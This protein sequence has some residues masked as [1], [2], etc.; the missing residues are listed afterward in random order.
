MTESFN[1]QIQ[2]GVRPRGPEHMGARGRHRL[3]SRHLP[4]R[5][6]R[7]MEVEDMEDGEHGGR[8]ASET[9]HRPRRR[10]LHD[11]RWVTIFTMTGG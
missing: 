10:H 2:R 9:R 5:Y 8:D 3:L 7:N 11:D 4:Y 6:L 1:S